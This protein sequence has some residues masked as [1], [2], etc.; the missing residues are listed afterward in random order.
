MDASTSL[1]SASH[2]G[3]QGHKRPATWNWFFKE[4][5]FFLDSYLKRRANSPNAFPTMKLFSSVKTSV[6]RLQTWRVK[7]LSA[8]VKVQLCE[9]KVPKLA[10]PATKAAT[11]AAKAAKAAKRRRQPSRRNLMRLKRFGRRYKK[12][13]KSRGVMECFFF[14]C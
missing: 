9:V 3:S 5:S 13:K 2:A 1:P 10:K 12:E 6:S 8:M 11:K 14:R 4:H 7:R